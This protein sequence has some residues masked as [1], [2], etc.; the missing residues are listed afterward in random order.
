[1]AA[2]RRNGE[3]RQGLLAGGMW[4]VFSPVPKQKRGDTP[5][6]LRDLPVPVG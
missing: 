2:I 5:L 1:M 6:A 4:A 3:V